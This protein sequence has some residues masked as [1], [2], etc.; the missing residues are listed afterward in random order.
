MTP[1][2]LRPAAHKIVVKSGEADDLLGIADLLAQTLDGCVQL[3][4]H[5]AGRLVL[6]H[7]LD[8]EEG[9]PA[10][11]ARHRRDAM[12]AGGGIE[13]QV[14]CRQFDRMAAV[15]VFDHQFAAVI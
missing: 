4:Q 15:C 8:P 14:S 6:D 7:A 2:C 5:G 12:A 3:E 11:A 9:R 13:Y 10:A 1:S